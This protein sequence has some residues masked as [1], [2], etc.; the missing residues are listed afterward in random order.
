MAPTPFPA[1]PKR[2][3]VGTPT[4]QTSRN[5]LVLALAG[6]THSP[7]GQL[8]VETVLSPGPCFTEPGPRWH[9][10]PQCLLCPHQRPANLLVWATSHWKRSL[11][12]YFC[13]HFNPSSRIYVLI[14]SMS[15]ANGLLYADSPC[16]K[17]AAKRIPAWARPGGP[18]YPQGGKSHNPAF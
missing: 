12:S 9:W 17:A 4:A 6:W 18:R 15:F 13:F 5:H 10:E 2:P 8:P 3:A 14:F 1:I 16:V 7:D 11:K